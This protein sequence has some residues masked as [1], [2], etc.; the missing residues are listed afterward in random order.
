MF[1]GGLVLGTLM[2]A[3]DRKDPTPPPAVPPAAPAPAAAAADP[4]APGAAP[5]LSPNIP[6]DVTANPPFNLASLQHDFDVLSWQ[7]FV[8]LNW[9]VLPNGQPDPARKPGQN[10]DNA[11]VWETYRESSTIFLP[12]G[13]APAPWG[14]KP[15]PLA[16]LPSEAKA[17]LAPGVRLLMQVGK[18]P[19]VLSEAVQPFNTGPLID[20]NGRYARFEI[21]V[22]QSMFD[23]IFNQ[24]LYSK[25]VQQDVKSV[26]FECGNAQ[27][28]QVGAIMVKA[29][30]K[31]L[32]DSEKKGGRF[33]TVQALIYTPPSEN[34]P[35]KEKYELA[36]VGLA[37]L[38]IVHK[39]VG[40]PQWVWSTFEQV[41]NCPTDGQTANHPA[42]S[43][44]KK[45][46]LAA[47][48]NTPPKRPWNPNDTEPPERRPQIVRMIP[49]D[50]ATQKLNASWQA[51]L[52]A[53]NPDSVWQHYELVSTQWPTAPAPA[54]DVAT[55]APTNMTGTP[56][57]QFLGNTTLESYIQG[58]VPNVSSSCIECHL[59][60]T[61]T[62]NTFSDFTYLLQRA[63]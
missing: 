61:T 4:A 5:V 36:T 24:K 60:A 22:N 53:V 1:C 16:S 63:Q 19:G 7:T 12:G 43:F 6:F 11:T 38:H 57:P 41:D 33:H 15:D 51:A 18:T 21:L 9:P 39:T 54:C 55:S 10:K 58:K 31:I 32:S 17:M 26:V 44:Y 48:I 45:G 37:G 13:A 30:W 27:T 25:K 49:I 46:D 34:P 2:L 47:P 62:T 29:A 50:A 8:A 56:A 52:R 35:I 23:T 59:N 3:C 20:Q 40:A 42:Y 14:G 28:R